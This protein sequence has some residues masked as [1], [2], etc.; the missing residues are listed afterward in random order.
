MLQNNRRASDA[1]PKTY[2]MAEV[3]DSLQLTYKYLSELVSADRVPHIKIGRSVR[4][5][6]NHV[7]HILANGVPLAPKR[8]Q[9]STARTKL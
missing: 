1:M 6:Q 8:P 2:T 9:R 3:A 7:D 4:F 5:T